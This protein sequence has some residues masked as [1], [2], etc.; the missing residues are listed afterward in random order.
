[1]THCCTGCCPCAV[2]G[3]VAVGVTGEEGSEGGSDGSDEKQAP[4]FS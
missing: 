3:G 4:L 1:V 2:G